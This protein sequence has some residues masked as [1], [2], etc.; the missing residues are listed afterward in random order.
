MQWY[1]SEIFG[2]EPAQKDADV[3]AIDEALNDNNNN[4]NNE[5]GQQALGWDEIS[6]QNP[7]NDDEQQD[8]DNLKN[9]LEG[10]NQVCNLHLV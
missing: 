9:D 5:Q 4:N 7:L 3:S 8:D 6:L 10:N 2:W 1:N